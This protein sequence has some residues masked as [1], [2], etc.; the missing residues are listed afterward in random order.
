V[1]LYGNIGRIFHTA[2]R[3]PWQPLLYQASQRIHGNQASARRQGRSHVVI[4]V[5]GIMI[6]GRSIVILRSGTWT[7]CRSIWRLSFHA[8][9]RVHLISPRRI[10]AGR[11][12]A[13]WISGARI[14][15]FVAIGD[16]R[17][18][19]GRIGSGDRIAADWIRRIAGRICGGSAG[20]KAGP[21]SLPEPVDLVVGRCSVQ[22]D[23]FAAQF[24]LVRMLSA[25]I[26]GAGTGLWA[27]RC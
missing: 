17:R 18:T 6:L 13:V 20:V 3:S 11:I 26:F 10:S 14:R 21:Y 4:R 24:G 19:S 15:R 27:A 12:G 1:V 7:K 22:L 2:H 8:W 9:R 5:V 25:V 16:V 23:V